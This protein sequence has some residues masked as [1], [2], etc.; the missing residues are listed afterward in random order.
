MRHAGVR[1]RHLKDNAFTGAGRFHYTADQFGRHVHFQ[2][3]VW[4]VPLT[5]DL[6]ADYFRFADAEFITFA[7]HRFDQNRQM[8]NASAGDFEFVFVVGLFDSQRNVG[9]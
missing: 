2:Q 3:F 7:P 9:F 1:G 5:I 8:Q 4:L 6:L